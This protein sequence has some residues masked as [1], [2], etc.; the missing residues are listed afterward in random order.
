MNPR[1]L[2]A[3]ARILLVIAVAVVIHLATT[4]RSYPLI[5]RISDKVNHALAFVVLSALTD[6]S[7]PATRFGIAKMLALL[8]FGLSIEAIQYFIPYRDASLGDVLADGVG[9]ALYA[10]CLPLLLRFP[11]LRRK[12]KD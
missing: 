4:D 11:V 10:A 12:A 9:I 5:E 7:F 2:R 3:L 6:Y 8:G 1:T